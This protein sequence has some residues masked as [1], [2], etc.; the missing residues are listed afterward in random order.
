MITTTPNHDRIAAALDAT[1]AAMVKLDHLL[2]RSGL[3]SWQ[4]PRM[5]ALTAFS[6]LHHL[7]DDLHAQAAG[8]GI[9]SPYRA[10]RPAVAA[11]PQAPALEITGPYPG[12]TETGDDDRATSVVEGASIG[13]TTAGAATCS[14]CVTEASPSH[15]EHTSASTSAATAT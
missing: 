9:A 10:P 5:H 7:R 3:P 1:Y 6:E 15:S 8:S 11:A 12:Q 14:A 4:A 2:A 13:P